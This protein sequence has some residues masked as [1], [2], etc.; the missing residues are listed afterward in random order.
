MKKHNKLQNEK[1]F[2]FMSC[3]MLQLYV[4]DDRYTAKKD[5]EIDKLLM[6]LSKRTFLFNK[7]LDKTLSE[8]IAKFSLL[9]KKVVADIDRPARKFEKKILISD[10]GIAVHGLLFA[11]AL[12]LEHKEIKNKTLYL[13]YKL[14]QDIYSRFDNAKDD[15]IDNS[16]IVAS[17]FREE[18]V[19]V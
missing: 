18:L 11:V 16:R 14:A 8:A 2:L 7:S 15:L 19:E 5:K 9:E 4:S 17:K 12:I 13:P 10:D 3:A 6:D 1:Y